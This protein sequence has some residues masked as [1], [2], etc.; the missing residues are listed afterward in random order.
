MFSGDDRPVTEEIS[1]RLET[2]LTF[3][4]AKKPP[5]KKPKK[6][7]KVTRQPSTGKIKMTDE[8]LHAALPYYAGPME[9]EEAYNLL[10]D[11]P[12]GTYILRRNDDGNYRVSLNKNK[13][14]GTRN[15]THVRIEET[16]DAYTFGSQSGR[17]LQELIEKYA[18]EGKSYELKYPHKV[19]LK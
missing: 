6:S 13:R 14:D 10:I 19:E 2:A 17:S 9:S 18:R 8:E 7:P 3:S 11:E 15:V 1:K 5:L 12:Q 4:P 16:K